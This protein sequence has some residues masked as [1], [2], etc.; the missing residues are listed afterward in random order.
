M[1]LYFYVSFLGEKDRERESP[2]LVRPYIAHA[3]CSGLGHPHQLLGL[4]II[5]RVI[6]QVVG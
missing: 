4:V 6:E 3:G 1:S 5:G 2:N